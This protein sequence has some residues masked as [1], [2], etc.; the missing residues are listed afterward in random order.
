MNDD[1]MESE[2]RAERIEEF[3]SLIKQMRIKPTR[4][5]YTRLVED[6]YFVALLAQ[7]FPN[8]SLREL[9]KSSSKGA[10]KLASL[11]TKVKE[12]GE[13]EEVDLDLLDSLGRNEKFIELMVQQYPL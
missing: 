4:D 7:R 13:D 12:Y 8:T 3:E 1:D 5:L 2:S 9:Q 6:Y 11:I 10:N